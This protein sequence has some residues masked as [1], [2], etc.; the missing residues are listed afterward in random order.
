MLHVAT[1]SEL[2]AALKEVPGPVGLVPTMGALHEGHMSLVRQACAEG[3]TVVASIFVNPAQFAPGEDLERYPR[4]LEH[5]LDLLSEAGVDVVFTPTVEEMYGSGS[6][7][8]VHVEGP[9]ESL[10]GAARPGHFD[11]VATVVAKLLIQ[12]SPDRAYFGR[13]DAQQVAVVRR[14]VADLDLPV[15]VVVLPTVREDDG[16]AISSRNAYLTAAQRQAAPVLFRALSAA[17]DR[18][19]SGTQEADVLEAGCRALIAGEPL[20]ESVDYVSVVDADTMAPWGGEGPCLMVA[21]VR[22]GEVRLIDNVV[23]D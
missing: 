15:Q 21:A 2:R 20:V 13:K 22:L 14:L 10:E 16:L 8:A 12:A 11:G 4:P 6:A 19:H 5:D 7:T 23:L 3:A 1:V 17:R 9:A 18:F